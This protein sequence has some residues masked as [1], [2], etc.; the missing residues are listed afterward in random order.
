M[1]WVK[2]L[3]YLVQKGFNGAA[4]YVGLKL[5]VLD[6]NVTTYPGVAAVGIGAALLS[7][8][9]IIEYLV[10]R[11]TALM[12]ERGSKKFSDAWLEFLKKGLGGQSGS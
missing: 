8:V 5:T 6:A 11:D 10:W 3:S 1:D 7:V 12:L 4:G 9:A 2:G